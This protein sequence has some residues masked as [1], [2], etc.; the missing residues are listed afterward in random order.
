MPG[1]P[2]SARGRPEPSGSVVY[3]PT[4]WNVNRDA[5]YAFFANLNL[6]VTTSSTFERIFSVSLSSKSYRSV[7]SRFSI[8]RFP[9]E[10]MS[11]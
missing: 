5:I 11:R 6:A 1:A 10:G 9:K 4:E 8:E 2:G 3:W 7:T